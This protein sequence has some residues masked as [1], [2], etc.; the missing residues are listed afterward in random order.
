MKLFSFFTFFSLLLCLNVSLSGQVQKPVFKVSKKQQ[1]ILTQPQKATINRKAVLKHPIPATPQTLQPQ[2]PAEVS[3]DKG[4]DARVTVSVHASARKPVI[5]SAKTNE[6]HLS[7]DTSDPRQRCETKQIDFTD[8]NQ[9]FTEFATAV[10]DASWLYPGSILDL[11]SVLRGSYR[12]YNNDRTP[13]T[14]A[15]TLVGGNVASPVEAPTST[16]VAQVRS[17]LIT[18]SNQRN[19]S[20]QMGWKITKVTSEMDLNVSVYGKYKTTGVEAELSSSFN[21]DK[22]KEHYMIDF[23][24]VAYSAFVDDL[25]GSAAF[26]TV[27]TG[28]NPAAMAYINNVVYGRRAI[29]IVKTSDRTTA[30][31]AKLRG[32]IESGVSSG[33]FAAAGD[34]KKFIGNT[35]IN[36][37]IYG[38]DQ[39]T[40]LRAVSFDPAEAL[41][42][43]KDYIQRSFTSNSLSTA[44]PIGYSLKLLANNDRC[45]V[46]TVFSAPVEKC[47][48]I[49]GEYALA[50]RI[51]GVKAYK[52]KDSDRKEDYRLT[53]ATE[54]TI[55]RVKKQ[56]MEKNYRGY[57]AAG[58]FDHTGGL[59]GVALVNFPESDQL[60]V[61]VGQTANINAEGVLPMLPASEKHN[62]GLVLTTYMCERSG[63]GCSGMVPNGGKRV[64]INVDA[65]I[66]WLTGA[67]E[68]SNYPSVRVD[69]DN[70]YVSM[71]S[72]FTAM[73]PV[74]GNG[75][76]QP[77][78][79]MASRVWTTNKNGREAFIYYEVE[80]IP[81]PAA[82]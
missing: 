79:K 76:N 22:S 6:R 33:A 27:P 63:D 8:V 38:G 81:T 74:Y 65:V 82:R 9:D 75:I 35:E 20:A 42:G 26:R 15:T 78:T 70:S 19:I 18:R 67:A 29:M 54:Y 16:G 48:P 55:D 32:A 77:A 34:Y 43:F 7:T 62:Y 80:L 56:F 5:G 40:A 31:K 57:K 53:V 12:T 64:P 47:V 39:G 72:S 46:Q 11:G 41:G 50:V 21:M 51:T 4:R 44:V 3:I 23:T 69:G 30:F 71:G 10:G 25:Q 2:L 37:I 49:L 68:K 66:S 58:Q 52:G 73:K 1:R 13:I 59:S 24:Q 28:A 61:P 36:V 60:H 45:T 14:L 17:N